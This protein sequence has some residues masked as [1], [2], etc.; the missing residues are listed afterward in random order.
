MNNYSKSI[1]N[2]IIRTISPFRYA[3][4]ASLRIGLKDK[5]MVEIIYMQFKYLLGTEK[6]IAI[7]IG[8]SI[9]FLFISWVSI[10]GMERRL[11]KN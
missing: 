10:K 8:L 3:T 11:F 1:F 5:P 2:Q 9:A 6:C 4:E 7:I